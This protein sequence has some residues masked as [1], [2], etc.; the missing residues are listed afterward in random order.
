MPTYEFRCKKCGK[1]FE[2]S[3]SISEFERMKKHGI[4]CS[5]CGSSQVKQQIPVF[6]AQTAK[7]S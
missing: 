3:C 5:S 6:Q 7:K 2:V 4:K 1:V